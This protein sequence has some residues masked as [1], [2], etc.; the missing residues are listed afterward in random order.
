MMVNLLRRSKAGAAL[1]DAIVAAVKKW[2]FVP[3]KRKGEA[4]S[5]WYHVG[6]P[7]RKSDG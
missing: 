5:C 4:V 2:T 6:V 7:V 1:D 3:A